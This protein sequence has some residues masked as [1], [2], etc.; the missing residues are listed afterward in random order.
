MGGDPKNTLH[1]NNDDNLANDERKT[2]SISELVK[3]MRLVAL[4]THFRVRGDVSDVGL[5]AL[6]LVT[7]PD[8][9]EKDLS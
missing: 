5:N 3:M 7:S 9:V 4:T 2:G 8:S 1:S 6:E